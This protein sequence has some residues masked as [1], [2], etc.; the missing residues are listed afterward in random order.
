[1]YIKGILS[2]SQDKLADLV[3]PQQDGTF[4]RV[5]VV[6]TSF[7]GWKPDTLAVVLHSHF[8]R[9]LLAFA[10]GRFQSGDL[11]GRLPCLEGRSGA[12]WS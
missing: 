3:H 8:A 1:M 9:F 12:G 4:V 7:S 6:E 5:E 2:N 10:R 11:I